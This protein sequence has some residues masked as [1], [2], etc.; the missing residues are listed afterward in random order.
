MIGPPVRNAPEKILVTE[1]PRSD[2]ADL[3]HALIAQRLR[4][5]GNGTVMS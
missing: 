1:F 5:F 3:D 2:A 4:I